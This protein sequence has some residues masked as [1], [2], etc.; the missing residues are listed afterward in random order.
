MLAR[1]DLVSFRAQGAGVVFPPIVKAWCILTM[2]RIPKSQWTQLLMPTQGMLPQTVQEYNAFIAYLRRNQHLFESGADRMKTIQ[3]PFFAN[4]PPT[5][6]FPQVFFQHEASQGTST[7]Y[8]FPAQAYTDA[9]QY[10]YD[11]NS[12]ASTT[13]SSDSDNISWHSFSTGK[14]DG[15]DHEDLTWED[16]AGMSLEDMQEFLYLQYRFAKRR[17]RKM[18]LKRKRF[19]GRR[20]FGKGGKGNHKGKGGHF[21]ADNS[22]Y[23]VD[24]WSQHS[25]YQQSYHSDEVFYKGVGKGHSKGNPMGNPIGR[26]GKQMQCSTCKSTEHFWKQCP[27]GKGK[28][29]GAG[30][31]PSTFPA[32]TQ[33]SSGPSS[34]PSITGVSQTTTVL[35][36]QP[37]RPWTP[38]SFFV[39][40]LSQASVDMKFPTIE[41]ITPDSDEHSGPARQFLLHYSSTMETLYPCWDSVDG[42]QFAFHTKVRLESGEALLVDTGAIN[43]LAGSRWLQRTSELAARAGQGT[44]IKQIHGQH[45]VGGVGTGESRVTHEATVPVAFEDGARGSYST[46]VIADSDLPALLALDPM[47]K[48][49]VMLDLINFKYYEVGPGGVKLTLSPGSRILDMHRAPT[50]HL[51]LPIT[52]WHRVKPLEKQATYLSK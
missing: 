13:A 15:D 22:M 37:P 48:R 21:W 3:Q 6:A 50:G 12:L 11:M 20:R 30:T 18:G 29:K 31:S 9:S 44:E 35:G 46:A 5:D 25:Q 45:T 28:G 1:Y 17:F 32:L 36:D 43:N 33:A 8:A 52:A 24:P 14:S 42:M 39:N 10:G 2:L 47:H 26:D 51:L 23:H 27:H 34:S 49:R 38:F 40:D 19:I 4:E 7:P 41:E 16:T